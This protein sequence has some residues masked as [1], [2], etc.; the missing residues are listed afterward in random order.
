MNPKVSIIVPCFGVEK[1]LDRCLVSLTQQTLKDIEIILVDDKSPDHVPEMCDEWAEKDSR[2]KVV[3]K[4]VNEG[5]GFARNT[6]LEIAIGEYIAF[7]DSDDFVKNGM[8]EKLYST[9][10]EL[11]A[12][13]VYSNIIYYEGNNKQKPRIDVEREKIFDG[14]DSVEEFLLDMIGPAPEFPRSTKYMVSVCYGIFK[15]QIFDECNIRFVSE[16]KFVSEDIIFDI[17]YLPHCNKI[18]YV[19]DAF[20]TYCYNESSLSHTVNDAKY[21]RMKVFLLAVDSRLSKIFPETKYKL[22]IQRYCIFL[23]LALA[24][25][26]AKGLYNNINLSDVLSDSFWSEF[27]STYPFHRMTLKYRSV[28]FLTRHK[29]FWPLLNYILK[30]LGNK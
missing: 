23:Y 21:N 30:H 1:Y 12:D 16:R 14:K 27:L 4:S 11:K 10:I 3:H 17:D 22:H 8:Y 20:Y 19:P 5:L 9:A 15:R 25:K 28:L 7:V 18:V 24:S 13:V 6:G 29:V 26:A 2:I